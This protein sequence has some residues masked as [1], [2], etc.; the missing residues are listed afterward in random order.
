MKLFY[1]LLLC[2]GTLFSQKEPP[3]VTESFKLINDLNKAENKPAIYMC[4]DVNNFW[5]DYL[6]EPETG[7]EFEKQKFQKRLDTISKYI[8]GNVALWKK[9]LLHIET[10][11]PRVKAAEYVNYREL[12]IDAFYKNH[13]RTGVY[14]YSPPLFSN[15]R[16][17]A[18]IY[19]WY[20]TG[21]SVILDNYYYC[22]KADGAWARKSIVLIGGF[23]NY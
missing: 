10:W 17:K 4:R 19:V 3:V 5:G 20:L 14:L 23:N 12:D 13:N 6:T 11:Q 18:L 1:A 16:T 22:E 15:D 7:S 21:R 8:G 2:F 9:S